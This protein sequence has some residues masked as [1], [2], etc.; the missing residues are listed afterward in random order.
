METPLGPQGVNLSMGQR[1]RI[2][3]ARALYRKPSLL[4]LDEIPSALSEAQSIRI[5]ENIRTL[6]PHTIIV[7]C[8]HSKCL[9]DLSDK[10]F[11][12]NKGELLAEGNA[13]KLYEELL[14]Y[15]QL[16]I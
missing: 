10:V 16:F 2:L 5:M 14:A 6:L 15:R 9:V 4:L 12:L 11:L 3:L 8:S 13:D 7:L 1:Q